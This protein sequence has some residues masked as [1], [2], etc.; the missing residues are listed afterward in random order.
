MRQDARSA[1]SASSAAA[2]AKQANEF[3]KYLETEGLAQY[4]ELRKIFDKDDDETLRIKKELLEDPALRPV[5][6]LLLPPAQLGPL[7][8]I[9]NEVVK[10]IGGVDI[11]HRHSVILPG[12]PEHAN[13]LAKRGHEIIVGVTD[14]YSEYTLHPLYTV[15]SNRQVYFPL[16]DGTWLGVKGIGQLKAPNQPPYFLSP[17]D[18]DRQMG[19][20]VIE[21]AQRAEKSREVF[22]D[23]KGRRVQFLGYRKLKVLPYEQPNLVQTASLKDP[24]GSPVVP[25]L[26]FN[27]TIH[28]HRLVKLPQLLDKDYG[29]KRL[30]GKISATL[31]RLGYLPANTRLSP[32]NLILMISRE[33]GV[34]EA[35]NINHGWYK[36]TTHSQDFNFA[37]EEH[38]NEEY[39]DKAAYTSRVISGDENLETEDKENLTRN[40]FGIAGV[41]RK[42]QTLINMI[43]LTQWYEPYQIDNLFPSRLGLLKEF[44]TAFFKNLD[45]QYLRYWA[46]KS[47]TEIGS[48]YSPL[49]QKMAGIESL[50]YFYPHYQ[51]PD[52]D[53]KDIWYHNLIL[54]TINQCA[55]EEFARRHSA[56]A[57]DAASPTS[58]MPPD[59]ER[60]RRASAG[61]T[62][63]G[64]SLS[65]PDI[66]AESGYFTKDQIK[67]LF[68]Y[69][70]CGKEKKAAPSTLAKDTGEEF[71]R[72]LRPHLDAIRQIYGDL[73]SNAQ[74][75]LSSEMMAKLE[76]I[77]DL[78]LEQICKELGAILNNPNYD[79]EKVGGNRGMLLHALADNVVDRVGNTLNNIH[80]AIDFAVKNKISFQEALDVIKKDLDE[81][82]GIIKGIKSIE[83]VRLSEGLGN[84]YI[85]GAN[86]IADFPMVMTSFTQEVSRVSPAAPA[87][88]EPEGAGAAAN[89]PAPSTA[90]RRLIDEAWA[91]I[92]DAFP[93][94][95]TNIN[96][97]LLAMAI[98][99]HKPMTIPTEKI[100]KHLGFIFSEMAT[101]G[102]KSD[103]LDAQGLGI[104]LPKLAM[105]GIRVAVLLS[106][107]PNDHARQEMLIR[108][109]NRK[110]NPDKPESDEKRIRFGISREEVNSQFADLKDDRPARFYY[111]KI[112]KEPEINGATPIDIIVKDILEIL[113]RLCG[114][115]KEGQEPDKLYEAASKFA[116]AA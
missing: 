109:L 18:S 113:G 35:E 43:M 58:P 79:A 1:A 34:S 92:E 20:V 73:S 66:L 15:A 4:E 114:I 75:P 6:L 60:L 10:A 69:G 67:R 31:V 100:D 93:G 111:L 38:D 29:L 7:E 52:D 106:K 12:S 90:A 30:A 47:Y 84:I 72:M 87:K 26:V 9:D 2:E 11:L 33:M 103:G 50:K 110:I 39:L 77:A 51:G 8:A 62:P 21:E 112:S 70:A 91:I 61:V 88:G 16:K 46:I 14:R 76:M 55:Q 95:T 45:D 94:V 28:P 59:T 74:Q 36:Y 17:I 65:T 41:K 89:G 5:F 82:D 64:P 68:D 37:G 24:D 83:E 80:P 85:P 98:N 13:E 96:T 78:Q 54:N 3:D 108:E 25:V 86:N 42:V 48:T 56:T 23:A 71:E 49:V 19:M 97:E 22:R 63:S 44:F 81:A 57:A 99:E 105:A 53:S 107:D 27:R 40:G 116:R 101:F 102:D 104:V 115:I 32:S